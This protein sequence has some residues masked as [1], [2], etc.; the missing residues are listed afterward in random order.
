MNK[1][2][3]CLLI[4]LLIS[5]CII[6]INTSAYAIGDKSVL[7]GNNANTGGNSNSG[8]STNKPSI[9]KPEPPK[10]EWYDKIVW[11]NENSSLS[12]VDDNNKLIIVDNQS[13]KNRKSTN[14]KDWRWTFAYGE[15]EGNANQ[16]L[17][18]RYD[19][20]QITFIAPKDGYYYITSTPRVTETTYFYSRVVTTKYGL[21][22]DVDGTYMLARFISRDGTVPAKTIVKSEDVLQNTLMKDFKIYLKAGQKFDPNPKTIIVKETKDIDTTEVLIK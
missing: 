16:P 6:N 12:W 22:E 10:V 5:V 18:E 8:G 21:K 20:Q 14:E 1:K 9:P 2:F 7:D 4:L 15:R 3:K 11:D 17:G 13:T 19:K